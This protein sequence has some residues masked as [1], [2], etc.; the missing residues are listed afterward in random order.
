M[1]SRISELQRQLNA[2]NEHP[3]D[4][5]SLE[6]VYTHQQHMDYLTN[7]VK[8]LAPL[9]NEVERLRKEEKRL[10]DLYQEAKNCEEQIVELVS[11]VSKKEAE[12]LELKK[13]LEL[14]SGDHLKSDES[15]GDV[16][17]HTEVARFKEQVKNK[18]HE[19]SRL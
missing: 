15:E 16:N 8:R 14:S 5:R 2:Q 4:G 18:D 6:Q 3:Q 1:E 9:E 13:Q 7:E 19:V 10:E 11:T 12:I 17:I